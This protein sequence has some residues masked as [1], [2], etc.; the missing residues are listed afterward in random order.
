MANKSLSGAM[1]VLSDLKKIQDYNNSSI[2]SNKKEQNDISDQNK[3]NLTEEII[4]VTPSLIKNWELKDRPDNELG[5]IESLALEF[6]E[7][8]QQVPCI[9]R[10]INNDPIYKYE[11]I[12]GE[13]RHKAS[14][15]AKSDLKVI[16]KNLTDAE[17]AIIQLSENN[18]RK[19]LSD[20]A[21]GINY[22]KI[23]DKGLLNQ[24]DL[25]QKLGLNKVAI[26]RLLSFRNIPVAVVNAIGD[27]TKVSARTASAIVALCNKGE[28]YINCVINHAQSIKKGNIGHEKLIK[29]V[30]S[31]INNNFDLDNIILF[32]YKNEDISFKWNIYDKKL[33]IK[34]SDKLKTILSKNKIEELTNDIKTYFQKHL[35]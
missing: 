19:N 11:L 14:I 15:L 9:V 12:A 26:S 35:D 23:I 7:I 31:K 33:T 20:Y 28:N 2:V 22:A 34:Y 27:M 25:T 29:I 21:K 6:S 16:V 17:A 3:K 1:S 13:R 32:N 5:N 8:G 10:P 24:N 4:L 30:N 18:N